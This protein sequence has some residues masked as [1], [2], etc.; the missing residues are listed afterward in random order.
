MFWWRGGSYHDVWRSSESLDRGAFNNDV[1]RSSKVLAWHCF[2]WVVHVAFNIAFTDLLSS[3]CCFYTSHR[4]AVSSIPIVNLPIPKLPLGFADR[5]PV[6]FA[7]SPR[8][9][10]RHV[11]AF[12]CDGSSAPP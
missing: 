6:I 9:I 11:S 1:Q 7:S 3:L 8:E 2:G 12:G 4:R 10:D 5:L